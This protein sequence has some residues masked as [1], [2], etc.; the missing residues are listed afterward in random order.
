MKRWPLSKA[1]PWEE[2]P[3]LRI[4]LPFT[5]GIISYDSKLLQLPLF[6]CLGAATILLCVLTM[7]SFVRKI[8]RYD[9]IASFLLLTML[10]FFLGVGVSAYYDITKRPGWFG[11]YTSQATAFRAT[12]LQPPQEK[13]KTRLLRVHIQA[14]TQREGLTGDALL[15]VYKDSLPMDVAQGDVIL[16]PNKL[17]RITNAGNPFE[18]DYAAYTAHNGIYYRQFMPAGDL[19]LLKKNAVPLTWTERCHRWCILQL[20]RYLTDKASLSLFSAML[21]G[22][23]TDMDASL[24]DAYAQTGIIHIISISG[25][26]VAVLFSIISGLLWWLR[27]RKFRVLKYLIALAPVWFYVLMAGAPPSAVRA[28]VMFTI[29]AGGILLQRDAR[30]LNTLLAAAF[31]LLF[32]NPYWLF[33]VGFQLSFAAVLSL[34]IFYQPILALWQPRFLLLKKLWQGIA[35]S[36]AA[37]I[38]IAPLVV[39]YFHSFPPMFIPANLV[40]ALFMGVLLLAGMLLLAC[41]PFGVPAKAIAW[42]CM[43]LVQW[44][45]RI[46]YWLQEISPAVCNRLQL[47]LAGLVLLYMVVVCLAV[48][49]LQR[50]RNWL[51]AGMSAT[52]ILL[53]HLC[54]DEWRTLHQDQLIVYNAGRRNYIERVKGN[55][56]AVLPPDDTTGKTLYAANAVHIQGHAY[57]EAAWRQ[58]VFYSGNKKLLVLQAPVQADS[59]T[60]FPVDVLIITA[61]LKHLSFAAVQRCFQ[62]KLIVFSSGQSKWYAA[63]WKD[64]CASHHIALHNTAADG[65][66]V[67]DL[68]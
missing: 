57:R 67:A 19:I 29:I 35:A 4:L 50:Q 3:F 9:T 64:S 34:I 12:V 16:F 52:I 36:I 58:D 42:L 17:Q 21:A 32:A 63:A 13:E 41:A 62:P 31:F 8:Y 45:H 25:S 61:R 46:I 10:L 2:A 23:E 11:K 20:Q 1:Y 5:G 6:I 18:F 44:F 65:A 39:Y 38:L 30:P 14:D 22:D 68:R 15:Y 47:S 37:E 7:F 48:A 40:A 59:N 43:L 54:A 28:A 55:T 66:F 26:H 53:L 60:F 51:L 49:W 56:Y 24:R 33:S 27:S